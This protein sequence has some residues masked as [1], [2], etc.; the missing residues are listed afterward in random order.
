[1]QRFLGAAIYFRP[2][3]PN[4]AE[5]TVKLYEMTGNDFNWSEPDWKQDYRGNFE[6]FKKAILHSFTLYHPDYNLEW[7]LK[8]D[9]SDYAVGG[10]LI[11]VS[12]ENGEKVQQVITFV[13]KKLSGAAIRWSTIEKECYGIFYSVN[14][15]KYYLTGKKFTILTDHHNLLW[16]QTSG[17]PKMRIFLQSFDFK[18]AHIPGQQNVFADWLSRDFIQ[19]ELALFG[20]LTAIEPENDPVDMIEGAQTQ[21][22]SIE[23]MI[24]LVHNAR[25]RP[26]NVESIEQARSRTFNSSKGYPRVC[27]QLYHLSKNETGHD[28]LVTSANQGNSTR[29]F[30]SLLRV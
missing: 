4:Y 29:T 15:L 14:K 26:Q 28:R 13:S 3:I 8:T 16:M 10:V 12:E 19:P 11:Q 7:I 6:E 5:K 18:I 25:M 2:F 20:A 17:V 24:T 22:D 23:S 1:M 21:P 30:K 9:A 27:G